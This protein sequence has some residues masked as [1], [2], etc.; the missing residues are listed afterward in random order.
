MKLFLFFGNFPVSFARA[1]S[2]SHVLLATEVQSDISVLLVVINV[3]PRP[4]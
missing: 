4:S 2:F 1:V 3:S